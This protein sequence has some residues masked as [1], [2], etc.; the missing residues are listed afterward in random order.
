RRSPTIEL[1]ADPD[2]RLRGHDRQATVVLAAGLLGNSTLLPRLRDQSDLEVVG[3]AVTTADAHLTVLEP[4]PDV[5]ILGLELVPEP[6]TLPSLVA[7]LSEQAP[8]VRVLVVAGDGGDE[9]DGA[10]LACVLAGAQA[11]VVIDDLDPV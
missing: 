3:Y 6:E 1:G 11:C 8:S 4:L 5:A 7:A 2:G 10:L 9:H